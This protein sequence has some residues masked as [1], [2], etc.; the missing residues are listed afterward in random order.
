[1]AIAIPS[2]QYVTT[3]NRMSGEVNDLLGVM[4]YARSEAVKE[5]NDVVV[6]SSSNGTSCSGATTWQNGWIVF[7]DPDNNGTLE[8]GETVLRYHGA[9]GGSDTFVPHDGTT[10][11]VQFSRDG[12]ALGLAS[13]GVYLQLHNS[14]ATSTYTRC[15][16]V[17]IV[18][19]LSTVPY[20]GSCQ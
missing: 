15:L 18:G 16:Q 1:M 6:C 10:T 13:A 8:A 11:E 5:G 19:A 9:F 4:Q 14:T 12:F 20:G 2:F 7:S 17:S 3:S